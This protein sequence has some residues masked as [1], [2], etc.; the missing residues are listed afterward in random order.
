[1]PCP[2]SPVAPVGFPP[3]PRPRSRREITI[4]VVAVLMAVVVPAIFSSLWGH[5]WPPR[6]LTE[7]QYDQLPFARR[8]LPLLG[9]LVANA[10]DIAVILCVVWL[11]REPWTRFG[12][13]W[14]RWDVELMDGV[15][16][17]C[18]SCVLF[19]FS[20]GLAK[21]LGL[22]FQDG[23]FHT[24][25][26]TAEHAL[27]I[28]TSI[29]TGISE[30]LAMRGYLTT[31]FEQLLGS[32]RGAILVTSILFALCHLYQGSAGPFWT[33]LSGLL[34]GMTFCWIRRLWPIAI[35]HGVANYLF[36]TW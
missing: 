7:A 18:I 32:S 5:L 31:R 20:Q 34:F 3:S 24:P 10:R 36:L 16:L 23:L 28:L 27:V 2:E 8:A 25:A 17:G 19:I 15:G 1:M 35:A 26:D 30:E 12:L 33:A 4:E 9:T 11:T 14:S 13:R 29:T 22:A 21:R 6:H